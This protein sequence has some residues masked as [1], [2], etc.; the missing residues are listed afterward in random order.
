[1]YP[2]G[3]SARKSVGWYYSFEMSVRKDFVFGQVPRVVH[4][5][6][7]SSSPPRY[8]SSLCFGHLGRLSVFFRFSPFSSL[9]LFLFSSSFRS[10]TICFNLHLLIMLFRM[11]DDRLIVS[12]L[13][14]SRFLFAHSLFSL[15]LY[16]ILS[17]PCSNPRQFLGTQA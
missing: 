16:H 9:L 6:V 15:Y 5:S 14:F 7:H 3:C 12:F 8:N 13:L 1:M 10:M 17:L 2:N 4:L 11:I